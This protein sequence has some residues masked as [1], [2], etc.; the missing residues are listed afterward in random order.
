MDTRLVGDFYSFSL[1]HVISQVIISMEF[2]FLFISKWGIC[3]SLLHSALALLK[4]VLGLTEEH[5]H[6]LGHFYL[7]IVSC[8]K[9][10]F[11]VTCGLPIGLHPICSI[12]KSKYQHKDMDTHV[13]FFFDWPLDSST[14]ALFNEAFLNHR[15]LSLNCNWERN[16]SLC[17]TGHI[18]VTMI[19][20]M[21]FPDNC[22]YSYLPQ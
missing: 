16:S 1:S 11:V 21:V 12:V 5:S 18:T 9:V 10:R 2:P 7:F 15:L 8:K 6:W 14:S 3:W 19:T 20:F 13:A 17:G 4:R 22:H